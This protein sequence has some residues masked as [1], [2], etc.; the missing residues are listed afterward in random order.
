MSNKN[1]KIGIMDYEGI[2]LNPLNN[3]KY[4]DKYKLLAA[5]WSKLPAYKERVGIVQYIKDNQVLLIESSTG[6]GK[7]VLIPKFALHAINYLGHIAIT[8]PKR[9]ITLSSAEFSA[10]TLDVK[11]GEEVGYQY[12]GTSEKSSSTKLLYA[13]DGTIVSRLMTDPALSDFDIVII[14]EAHERKV[15]IDLLLFLLRE[16]LKIR[17]EFKI[18]IMSATINANLFKKYYEGFK[19]KHIQLAGETHYPI[20]SIFLDKSI[21]YNARINKGFEILLEILTAIDLKSDEERKEFQ[22]IIFFVTSQNEAFN[23]CQRLTSVIR[24]ENEQAVCKITCNNKILCV[25]LFSGVDEKI[26]NLALS[27]D[28]RKEGFS[29]K[30]IFSTNVAESSLT[31]DSVKY[32]IDNGYELRDH[33]DPKIRADK[34]DKVLITV[35]QAKQRMG[36]AGRTSPGICYHLYTRDEFENIMEKFPL[37]AIKTSNIL[38]ECLKILSLEKVQT[39]DNLFNMIKMFIEPPDDA[40]IIDAK[41]QIEQLRFVDKN[42]KINLLGSTVAHLTDNPFSSLCL[43]Y[44]KILNCSHEVLKIITMTSISKDNLSAILKIPNFN[45]PKNK[46][47]IENYDRTKKTLS[48]KYGDHL[49]LL[50]IFELY[51]KN[52]EK[53]SSDE[54]TKWCIKN[55]IKKNTLS[56]ASKEYKKNKYKIQNKLNDLDLKEII[57][58]LNFDAVEEIKTLKIDDKII[59]AFAKSFTIGTKYTFNDIY[60]TD[61]IK[62]SGMRINLF[63]D[64]HSFLLSINKNKDLPMKVVFGKLFIIDGQSS[65]LIV[66]KIPKIIKSKL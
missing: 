52:R 11:L 64:K 17:P 9:T 62:M 18:I 15:Q 42:G 53:L 66:S 3:Q 56:N 14:D 61:L 38:S 12:K 32:V 20:E 39:L 45:D 34:L 55:F 37:P 1:D 7:T 35:A 10:L 50:R 2:N 51:Q 24:R 44:G 8:L 29:V 28:Y 54:L 59:F 57:N 46:N 5:T 47:I 65:L 13:T 48:H 30:V 36:R 27:K 22:D 43:I 16:T 23:L 4:S 6:S 25:E 19:F 63:I 58:I 21:N 49:S 41:N 31:V 60:S 26:K 33:Y 40:F